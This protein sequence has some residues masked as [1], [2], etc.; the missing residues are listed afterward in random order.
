MVEFN[1]S[2][3]GNALSDDNTILFCHKRNTQIS[4]RHECLEYCSFND[5]C[6]LCH[7][8]ILVV[9]VWVAIFCKPIYEQTV[10][11]G[12]SNHFWFLKFRF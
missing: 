7:S 12:D 11:E 6:L 5:R 2:H 10:P 9:F 1:V 8:H 3:N 4:Y